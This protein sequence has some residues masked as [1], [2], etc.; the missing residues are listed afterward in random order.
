MGYIQYI[1]LSISLLAAFVIIVIA[2]RKGRSAGRI[3]K[4]EDDKKERDATY[5]REI[6]SRDQ[7]IQ[8]LQTR[9]E[10]L[11]K[12]NDR[13]L[14][15]MLK[16]P[17]IVQRL[18]ATLNFDEII[19]SINHL[20]SDIV[21]TDKIEIYIL[22]EADN[23]L[24][25]VPFQDQNQEEQISYALG[26]GLIGMAAHNRMI[27]VNRFD[28][29][30][31]LNRKNNQDSDSQIWMAVPINF[32][33]R[34]LG[35][36]GIGQ[37][38]NPVGNEGDLLKMIADI[39]GVALINQ[40]LLGEAKQEANTDPLTGLNNR[41]YFFKMAQN[42]VEKSIREGSPIS[43][44]LFDIDHFKHYNDTNGHNEGDN[45]L[46]EISKIVQG[47]T[48]KTSVITRYG[49]EE[50]IVMLPGIS[51]ED[52]FLYAERLREK[53][54]AHPF[55]HKEKQPLGCVSISGGIATFPTDGDS[56]R[57]VIQLVDLALYK[58][59]AAGRNCIISHE[60]YL[61]SDPATEGTTNSHE[62]SK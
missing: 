15:F 9:I 3:E 21:P 13:Y 58:A 36:I 25:K 24:K 14:S 2:Y 60:P 57:K 50:F 56:I 52:A 22:D 44:F 8:N 46:K 4:Q 32:S 34:L 29:K 37:I 53:I 7:Q 40:A 5:L 45:V 51:K 39:A 59:K 41:R 26:D 33:D 43:I 55:P 10:N 18:N 35:V 27:M 16:V 28:K 42:F 11:N 49:G 47:I 17:A 1:I 38:K 12:L 54:S 6:L 20:V 23:L 31:H 62:T 30:R 19:T 61:F 48:R